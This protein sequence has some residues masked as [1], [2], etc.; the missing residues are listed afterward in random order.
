M[1][2]LGEGLLVKLIVPNS[3]RWCICANGL[4]ELTPGNT[5][6]WKCQHANEYP[7]S[8]FKSAVGIMKNILF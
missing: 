6:H 7:I 5:E 2:K 4:V 1:V 3:V 8:G